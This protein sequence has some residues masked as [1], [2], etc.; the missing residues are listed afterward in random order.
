MR[1]IFLFAFLSCAVALVSVDAAS[2]RGCRGGRHGGCDSGC[3]SSC[4]SACAPACAPATCASACG[5]YCDSGCGHARHHR[6]H[7]HHGCGSSCGS[8]GC[9]SVGCASGCGG[10]H[11]GLTGF[12]PAYAYAELPASITLQLPADAVVLID[13]NATQST[14]SERTFTT[15]DLAVD[16][17]QTYTF[18][19]RLANGAVVTRQVNIRGGE[20]ITLLVEAPATAVAQR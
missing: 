15:P 19:V 10:G 17:T 12:G 1:R 3:G 6:G 14:S 5:S 4:G 2:A 9:G 7:R 18:E 11:C 16:A 8:V 13:G 20:S